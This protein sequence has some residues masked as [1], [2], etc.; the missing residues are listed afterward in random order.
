MNIFNQSFCFNLNLTY[1]FSWIINNFILINFV[2][3]LK[4][5]IYLKIKIYG[6]LINIHE[7]TIFCGVSQ[8]YICVDQ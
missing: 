6:L 4:K 3:F 1:L 2:G 8:D 5:K 7:V